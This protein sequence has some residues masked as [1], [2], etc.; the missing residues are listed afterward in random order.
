MPR[1]IDDT[2]YQR[3]CLSGHRSPHENQVRTYEEDWEDYTKSGYYPVHIVDAFSNGRHIIV[4]RLG[5]DHFSTVWLV[6]DTK[7]MS[8]VVFTSLLHG[9]L[10]SPEMTIRSPRSRIGHRAFAHRPPPYSPTV[11]S[12]NYHRSTS[13]IFRYNSSYCN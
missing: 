9:Y 12:L 6:R 2:A 7:Y 11:T 8:A 1:S 10:M 3:H 5:W 13:R 4:R